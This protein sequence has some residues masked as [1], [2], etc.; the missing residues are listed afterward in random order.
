M[1]HRYNLSDDPDADM[2]VAGFLKKDMWTFAA[3]HHLGKHPTSY[4]PGHIKTLQVTNGRQRLAMGSLWRYEVKS[5][6]W[7]NTS[8]HDADVIRHLPFPSGISLRSPKHARHS[9]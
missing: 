5:G 6:V 1:V 8:V 3:I 2:D 7:E 4:I 9:F